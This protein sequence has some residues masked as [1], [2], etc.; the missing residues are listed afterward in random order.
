MLKP[1]PSTQKEQE[2]TRYENLSFRDLIALVRGQQ[3]SIN[4]L[5]AEVSFL[6][7]ER[8]SRPVYYSKLL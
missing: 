7:Q 4:K 8:D 6:R 3:Y 5:E 2:D 1:R